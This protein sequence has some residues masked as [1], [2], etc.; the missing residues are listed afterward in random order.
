MIPRGRQEPD[1]VLDHLGAQGHAEEVTWI[2]DPI[3]TTAAQVKSGFARRSVEDAVGVQSCC[4][5]A[6]ELHRDEHQVVR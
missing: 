5:A 4:I 1:L 2:Q 6:V 3:S